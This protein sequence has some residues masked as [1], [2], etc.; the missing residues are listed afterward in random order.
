MLYVRLSARTLRFRHTG[1]LPYH[2]EAIPDASSFSAEGFRGLARV[3]PG[4]KRERNTFR[5][6][7]LAQDRSPAATPREALKAQRI[8]CI[9]NTI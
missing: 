5:S 9:A 1:V 7:K 4:D 2:H 3:A 8:T 6:R